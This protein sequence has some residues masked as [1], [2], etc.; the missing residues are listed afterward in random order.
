MSFRLTR[1]GFVRAAV[2][3]QLLRRKIETM[4]RSTLAALLVPLCLFAFAAPTAAAADRPNIVFILADDL[5]YGDLGSYGQRVIQTPRLDRMAAEGIRFTQFYAGS[6]VCAPS[7]SVLMTGQHLGHTWVRGNAGA[8]NMIIQSLR[9][10]DITVAE[11]LKRAGYATALIGKWGLG[12]VGQPGHPLRQGFDMFFGYLN[13]VHAHN[14]YPEFLWRG[15]EKV[16]LSNVVQPAPRAYGGFRGGWAT[17]RKE[18]SHDLFMEE[19]LGWIERHKDGPF[20]LYLALTIPHANN[21]GT[22]G[23]GNGQEV[24]D[25]GIYARE[26]WPE[27]DKGQA[28]MITRMDRDVG[29]LLDLLRRLGID[30]NTLVLFSSDNGPH[31][32][33][34]NDPLRFNP[35]GPLRGMKRDLYEGGVRVPF[36]AWWPGKIQPNRTSD[37]VGYFGDF[38]ATA[39]EL[40]GVEPP[41]G[42]DSVSFLPTLLGETSRQQQHDYL[43]WEFYERGSAQA[44]GMGHWKAVRQPMW[45]GRIELYDLSRDPAER[46]DIARAHPDVVRKVRA[47][48]RQAHV[49]NDNWRAPLPCPVSKP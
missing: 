45:T 1:R 25:Y 33:G 28:A 20:F 19:A 42:I 39:C 13:Q 17:V 3:R 40:A 12:E 18:Y 23:T 10:E 29:R 43:Y 46:Y 34:G 5:G 36:I 2:R 24:P 27:P 7:R 11:M 22:R 32:E 49:H 30:K 21:E 26:D 48:M 41:A 31:V 16:Q 44:V 8:G 38:M 6:T 9:D 4:K 15:L 35:S 14:Y 37:H 47:I